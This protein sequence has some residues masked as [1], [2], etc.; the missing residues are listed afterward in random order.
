[1][2]EKTFDYLKAEIEIAMVHYINEIIPY[3]VVMD[4]SDHTVAATLNQVG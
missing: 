2:A 4:A 3:V 1:M